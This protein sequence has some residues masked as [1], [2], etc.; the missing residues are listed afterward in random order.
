MEKSDK[1]VTKIDRKYEDRT[2]L[3]T[4]HDIG[5]TTEDKSMRGSVVCYHPVLCDE[6]LLLCAAV[7]MLRGYLFLCAAALC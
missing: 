3:H 7:P 2:H 4:R 5:V 1:E 6:V